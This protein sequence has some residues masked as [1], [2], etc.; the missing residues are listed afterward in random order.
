[1]L[2]FGR[3]IEMLDK[4]HAQRTVRA[5]G[6]K[7]RKGLGVAVNRVLQLGAVVTNRIGVDEDGRD[8]GVDHRRSQFSDTG[9]IQIIDQV[10]RREHRTF[11][12]GFLG[13]RVDKFELHF[14]GGKGHAIQF[15]TTRFLHLTIGDRDVRNNGLADIGL[16]NA[17]D[18]DAIF[19]HATR[20]DQSIADGEWP[21][22]G[23]QV[24]AIAT[25]I[26]KRLVDRNLPEKIIDIVLGLAAFGEDHGFAGAGCSATHAVDLFA[27]RIG[28]ADDTQQQCIAR[29]TGHLCRN[30]QILQA[31][32]HALA[33][34][35]T[36]V[37][38]GD[39][40]LG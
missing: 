6:F 8:A 35:A 38:G 24:S 19:R 32:E 16:P 1:M 26:N 31:E 4:A 27:V 37:G 7:H 34:A 29:G 11:G 10:S 18:R 40:Y 20:I 9:N 23:A 3:F 2:A 5:N 21:D 25:P 17:Y 36:H 39:F 13:C 28:T 33:G 22:G 12:T 14:G 15:E 30:G